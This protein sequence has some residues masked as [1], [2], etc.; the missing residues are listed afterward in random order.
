M[1]SRA[2]LGGGGLLLAVLLAALTWQSL[3]LAGLR[4]ELANTARELGEA[5]ARAARFETAEQAARA[6]ADGLSAQ[7]SACQEANAREQARAAGRAVI[8]RNAKPVPAQ[9]GKV[10]D[11]ATSRKAAVH[12]NAACRE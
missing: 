7:V 4:V 6:A 11:D 5:N 3:R 2:I 10:V 12:L 8:V 9:A 1:T